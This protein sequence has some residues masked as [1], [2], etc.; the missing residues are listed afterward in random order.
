M[1]TTSGEPREHSQASA[2]AQNMTSVEDDALD[3]CYEES[4]GDPNCYLATC[5]HY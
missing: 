2:S 1:A 3:R 5:S 4:G